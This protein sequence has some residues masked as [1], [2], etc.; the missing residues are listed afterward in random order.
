MDRNPLFYTL[1]GIAQ[2]ILRTALFKCNKRLYPLH[3]LIKRI[4]PMDVWSSE[5]I[6][7]ALDSM[8]SMG[9][10]VRY[11]GILRNK[12]T[13][14]VWILPWDISWTT[15]LELETAVPWLPK[16]WINSTYSGP[17][18]HHWFKDPSDTAVVTEELERDISMLFGVWQRATGHTKATLDTKRKRVLQKLL[19]DHSC[20]DIDLA[21]RGMT[22]SP[23]HMG[24]N[25]QKAVYDD[26]RYVER[27]FDNFLRLGEENEG[28]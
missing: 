8:E 3:D 1:S 25:D 15:A 28:V 27:N 9:F 2:A 24:E 6:G 4:N 16:Q 11:T 20:E 19:K 5:E 14:M 23:H 7:Q 21:I 26:L 18:E 17:D 10:I 22:Y 12:E 13:N